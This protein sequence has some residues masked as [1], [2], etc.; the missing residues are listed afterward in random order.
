MSKIG[1]RECY[2]IKIRPQNIERL[3][4]QINSALVERGIPSECSVNVYKSFFTCCGVSSGDI[5]I[6]VTGPSE[7]KIRALDLRV[8]SKILEACEKRGIDCHTFGP[9]EVV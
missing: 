3:I 4:E 5:I 2:L 9:L 1:R 8:V 7:E 6:E